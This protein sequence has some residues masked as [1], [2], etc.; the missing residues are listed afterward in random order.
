MLPWLLYIL[1]GYLCNKIAQDL[2]MLSEQ[3]MPEQILAIHRWQIKLT[4]H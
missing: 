4:H 1:F 3:H 2:W